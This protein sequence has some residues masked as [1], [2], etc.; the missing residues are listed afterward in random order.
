MRA[1]GAH[2]SEWTIR[3][4]LLLQTRCDIRECRI[5][6]TLA[7]A[8]WRRFHAIHVLRAELCRHQQADSRRGIMKGTLRWALVGSML[9][10]SLAAQ[11]RSSNATRSDRVSLSRS[12]YDAL[13]L[14]ANMAHVHAGGFARAL[15]RADPAWE[16]HERV[17]CGGPGAPE[18]LGQNTGMSYI[19]VNTTS[20]D[21]ERRAA[22]RCIER[23]KRTR[24]RAPVHEPT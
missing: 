17:N 8:L 7:A 9:A 12:E 15:P 14:A 4:M 22:D 6:G 20:H 16:R 21:G 23:C 13:V 19:D 1:P 5:N 2:V 10:S 11:D 24:K 3:A 18:L